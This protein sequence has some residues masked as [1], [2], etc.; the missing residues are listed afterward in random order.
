MSVKTRLG[1]LAAMVVLSG[2]AG[3]QD[4]P[5]AAAAGLYHAAPN[6]PEF[7]AILPWLLT[8]DGQLLERSFDGTGYVA[9]SGAF[10]RPEP[11]GDACY[12]GE[13]VE[14]ALHVPRADGGAPRRTLF[15]DPTGVLILDAG[16][17]RPQ[18]L[19]RCPDDVPPLMPG[20]GIEAMA[21]APPPAVV[22]PDALGAAG[23]GG[24]RGWE[25][26]GEPGFALAGRWGRLPGDA[27]TA[28]TVRPGPG[29]DENGW[30]LAA[31]YIAD[32]CATSR[33][34]FSDRG[35]L[36]QFRG[37]SEAIGSMSQCDMVGAQMNCTEGVRRDNE[38]LPDPDG[39]TRSYSV[40]FEAEDVLLCST[41]LAACYRLVR[42]AEVE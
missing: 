22:D 40:T 18:A 31:A 16:S 26:L 19:T 20:F 1:A 38:W 27:A 8:G 32:A 11:G 24:A 28:A 2:P 30:A 12:G 10:C 33:L 3:A 7:C 14:G 41:N 6:P 37:A 4:G 9:R 35:R 42:C 29:A 36:S 17:T 13:I 39:E 21:A 15:V 23:V 34:E 25:S 5:Y